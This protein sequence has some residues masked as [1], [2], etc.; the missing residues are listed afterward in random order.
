MKRVIPDDRLALLA[1]AREQ[2]LAEA[3]ASALAS[4]YGTNLIAE[5]PPGSAARLAKET[6][7]DPM[8]WLLV[9]TSAIFGVIGQYTDM[10]VLLAAV[11][12][13]VGMDLYLHRR[14]QASIEGLRSVLAATARVVREGAERQVSADELVPGGSR[15]RHRRRGLSGRRYHHVRQL[16]SGRR[17]L[18]DRRGLRRGEASD[19]ATGGA[20]EVDRDNV[21]CR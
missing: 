20:R 6:L 14:T 11:A 16:A 19:G 12:P 17:I 15:A 18:P 9:V 7:A 2:G 5:H 21:R 4:Q 8:I 1:R 3:D 13:L 10:A